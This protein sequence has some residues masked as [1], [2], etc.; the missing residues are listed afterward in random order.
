MKTRNWYQMI[1]AERALAENERVLAEAKVMAD[2]DAMEQAHRA[3]DAAAVDA[4]G[5]GDVVAEEEY[6]REQRRQQTARVAG[7]CREIDAIL[8]DGGDGSACR[9]PFWM[10][11]PDRNERMVRDINAG[12]PLRRWVGQPEWLVNR[13]RTIARLTRELLAARAELRH[14]QRQIPIMEAELP[15]LRWEGMGRD[16]D[17]GDA[18]HEMEHRV[19][20]LRRDIRLIAGDLCDSPLNAGVN[21]EVMRLVASL[22]RPEDLPAL[23]DALRAQAATIATR[24]GW[25]LAG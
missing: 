24:E 9:W 14:R 20:Q 22:P 8:A 25:P 10:A 13:S 23:A 4:D 2:V 6:D 16:R 7:Y 17:M 18:I 11:E 19:R 12:I 21:R 3:A 1:A 15:D 5:W